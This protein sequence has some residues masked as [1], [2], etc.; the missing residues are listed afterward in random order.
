M[1]PSGG[2]ESEELEYTWLGCHLSAAVGGPKESKLRCVFV[3]TVQ[4]STKL[5]FW[6]YIVLDPT[7]NFLKSKKNSFPILIPE[8][9]LLLVFFLP[10]YWHCTVHASSWTSPCFD[11]FP[12]CNTP[13]YGAKMCQNSATLGHFF[14]DVH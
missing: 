5:V 9:S 3:I 6:K 2:T 14:T 4:K 10:W 11:S 1:P 13:N 8:P 7:P 12:A